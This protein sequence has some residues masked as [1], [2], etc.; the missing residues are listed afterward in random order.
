MGLF[1]I[2]HAFSSGSTALTGVEAISNGV[3]AFRRPQAKNASTTLAVMAAIAVTMFLGI[4]FLAQEGHAIP[5][6]TKSVVAQIADGVFGHGLLYY[7]IQVFTAAI[8]ILAANTSYQDF[9]RLASIL[10]RDRFLP[11]QF[12]NRGD[13]LVFSNGVILLAVFACLLIVIFDAKLDNLIQLYVV[14]VFT[15][16]TLSQAGMV[17]H[18]LKVRREGGPA[19]R[20]WRRSIVINAVGAAATFLVLVVVIDTKFAHGAWIVIAAMPLI[21]GMFYGIHRHYGRVARQLATTTTLSP[22][23]PRTIPILVVERLD[24][25]TAEALGYVRGFA[26]GDFRA[27]HVPTEGSD[28]GIRER[29]KRFSHSDVELE[30][31]R[32]SEHPTK[33]ILDHIRAIPRDPADFVDVVIPEQLT[34]TSL[35][36]A[37]VGR[38]TFRLKL[39]LLLEPQVVITDVPVLAPEGAPADGDPLPLIPQRTEVMVFVSGVNIAS[40]RAIDYA[41]SLKATKTRAVFFALVPRGRPG[42]HRSVDLGPD[43]HR[44]RHRRGAVP[45]PRPAGPRGGSQGD[46]PRGLR[47]RGGAPRDRADQPVRAGPAQP[48]GVLHQATAAVRAAGDPVERPDPA[49]EGEV[50]WTSRRPGAWPGRRPR[51]RPPTGTW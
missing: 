11:R 51:R 19:A 20:G 2:L 15:S 21:I 10:A 9:P 39:R 7:L 46:R 3:P 37:V 18:W 48:A 24:A 4:S 13:R 16:F 49:Q 47:G 14:G 23:V 38:T 32:S 30:V 25:A 12:E 5:S 35:V 26:G 6:E 36:S 43:P 34:K 28:P 8:L 33:T 17:R 40:M 42:D 41:R 45:R 29:W 44:A 22:T 50:T 1:V 31:L 27:V